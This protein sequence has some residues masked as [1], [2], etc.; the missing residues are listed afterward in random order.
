[1]RISAIN[2]LRA[3]Y[4]AT[5]LAC[6]AAYTV[7]SAKI[8]DRFDN[9]T[10]NWADFGCVEA[11][12]VTNDIGATYYRV[13]IE[14]AGPGT[15]PELVGFIRDWLEEQGFGQVQVETEW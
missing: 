7:Y 1:M 12:R 9:D 14:E 10:V 4:R 2:Y 5:D 15:C 11:E 3:L 6:T 8:S 13:L